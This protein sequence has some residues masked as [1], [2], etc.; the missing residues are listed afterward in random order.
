VSKLKI[1]YVKSSIGY[2]ARQRLTLRSLGLRRLHQSVVQ[3]DV[4]S[5]RGMI[6]KVRHLVRVEA[7]SE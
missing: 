4:R 6:Q 3:E 2:A 5:V 1:T 7:V